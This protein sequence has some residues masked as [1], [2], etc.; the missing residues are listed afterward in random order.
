MLD[1]SD[2]V[3][4]YEA[5]HVLKR[6]IAEMK[7]L[8]ADC[9]TMSLDLQHDKALLYYSRTIKRM[10]AAVETLDALVDLWTREL[11]EVD[12]AR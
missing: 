3:H 9:E 7:S 8:L 5:R 12:N 4:I 11:T 1:A 2:R 6:S 10:E